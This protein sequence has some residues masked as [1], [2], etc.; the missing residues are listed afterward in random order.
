M[1][2]TSA[3]GKTLMTGPTREHVEGDAYDQDPRVVMPFNGSSASADVTA[4][5][6]YANY[7]RPEDFQ[8]LAQLGIDVRGK[9]VL[10]RYGGNFRGVKVYIAQQKGAAGVLIYSDPADDGYFRGD[11]YPNGPYRPATGV[12]RG[13]VQYMFKYPGDPTTPG[14]ASTPDCRCP[15]ALRPRRPRASPPSPRPRSPIKMRRRSSKI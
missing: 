10:A 2:A 4:D 7:G 14:V 8:K 9:I 3:D 1:E 5:V 15:S 12:Q 6:V 13:S 11:M